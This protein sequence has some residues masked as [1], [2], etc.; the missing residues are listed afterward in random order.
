ME[1]RWGVSI[2]EVNGKFR[3]EHRYMPKPNIEE[4]TTFDD[5]MTRTV[6]EAGTREDA[7]RIKLDYEHSL[8]LEAE[9]D[10]EGEQDE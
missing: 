4:P 10:E 6:G 1:T 8:L 9:K 7:E 5:E 2:R 3:V